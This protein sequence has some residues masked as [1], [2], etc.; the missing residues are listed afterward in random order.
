MRKHRWE[1]VWKEKI[2]NITTLEPSVLVKRYQNKLLLGDFVL[3]VGCGNGR[4]S[5]YLANRGCNIDCFDVVNLK[6]TNN[7]PSEIKNRIHFKKSSILKYNYVTAKYKA[8]IITRLIQYLNKEELSF[9]ID[10][11]VS[12]LNPRGFILLNYATEG[13]IFEREEIDVPKYHH[14][15]NTIEKMLKDKFENVIITKGANKSI[16]V[17]Y[18]GINYKEKIIAYDIF[19]SKPRTS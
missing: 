6:W 17:Y 8:V 4:N 1:K 16:H 10:K 12:A 14:P 9:L 15:I 13:K 11:A 5:I 18:K 19:A 2:F 7:L 3:D